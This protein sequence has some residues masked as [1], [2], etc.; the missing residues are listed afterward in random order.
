MP[1]T[2]R[3]AHFL[4]RIATTVVCGLFCFTADASSKLHHYSMAECAKTFCVSAAGEAA[5]ISNLSPTLAAE[6][7]SLQIASTTGTKKTYQC[8][9]MAYLMESSILTCDLA[10]QKKTLVIDLANSEF[11]SY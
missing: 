4:A 7:V 6:N 5:F 10:G 9:S 1:V 11:H 8:S 3:P 2:S